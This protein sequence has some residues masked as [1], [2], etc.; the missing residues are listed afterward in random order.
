MDFR[1]DNR[2]ILKRIESVMEKNPHLNFH[3]VLDV[4]GCSPVEYLR[5]ESN[6]MIGKYGV[7]DRRKE[8]S[9]TTLSRINGTIRIKLIEC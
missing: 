7:K 2:T 4:C 3:Q 1:T 9:N 5:D 6:P 8:P